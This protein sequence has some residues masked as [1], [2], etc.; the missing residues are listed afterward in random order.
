[1]EKNAKGPQATRKTIRLEDILR[2]CGKRRI[3]APVLEERTLGHTLPKKDPPKAKAPEKPAAVAD[4]TRKDPFADV[5]R[6][7]PGPIVLGAEEKKRLDQQLFIASEQGDLD[8]IKKIISEAGVDN[9]VLDK[10][11]ELP[12]RRISTSPTLK[13]EQETSNREYIDERR[14]LLRELAAFKK[15]NTRYFFEGLGQLAAVASDTAGHKLRDRHVGLI[16]VYE[17]VYAGEGKI[18]GYVEKS[19]GW[20]HKYEFIA[21]E[22]SGEWVDVP[23]LRMKKIPAVG[24]VHIQRRIGFVFGLVDQARKEENKP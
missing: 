9:W 22:S 5:G 18:G 12:E 2:N 3:R 8:A 7:T 17:Q 10:F 24:P 16:G 15:D 23:Y 6:I 14:R 21:D 19:A 4:K 1:M 11:L 13:I 20:A